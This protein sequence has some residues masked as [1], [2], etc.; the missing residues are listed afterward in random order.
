M[1][2]TGSL[3]HK[4]ITLSNA[5]VQVVRTFGGTKDGGLNALV[6]IYATQA[7]RE[8]DENNFIDEVNPSSLAPY[9]S[10]QDGLAT[11]YAHLQAVGGD[12]AGFMNC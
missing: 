10:G 11:M 6:R 9:V 4:G 1:A 7:I 5:Y 8:A 12:Y 2:I 3:V